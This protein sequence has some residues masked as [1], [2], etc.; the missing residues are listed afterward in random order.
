MR[1]NKRNK[2]RGEKNDNTTST[3][4]MLR[5]KYSAIHPDN[6]TYIIEKK[7][8]NIDLLEAKH[9]NISKATPDIKNK[10]FSR[11]VY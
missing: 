7:P 6:M 1:N 9:I 5:R 10:I 3:S 2:V 4:F 11:E 8:R